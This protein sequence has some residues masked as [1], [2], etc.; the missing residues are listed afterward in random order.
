MMLFAAQVHHEVEPAIVEHIP[1]EIS[2]WSTF[3]LQHGGTIEGLVIGSRWHC[4]EAGGMEIP[5][6]LTFTGKKKHIA[7]LR[8]LIISL[9]SQTL[10]VV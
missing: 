5:C 10:F 3:F 9:K 8:Q 4:T 2:Q 6:R 7:R 1:R